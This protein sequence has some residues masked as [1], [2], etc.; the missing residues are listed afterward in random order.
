MWFL[1][2]FARFSSFLNGS[3][4]EA[5]DFLSSNGDNTK[6]SSL[7]RAS[8]WEEVLDGVFKEYFDL[9]GIPL[10]DPSVPNGEYPFDPYPANEVLFWLQIVNSQS[11]HLLGYGRGELVKTIPLGPKESQKVSVKIQTR[12]KM[13]RSSENSSSFETSADSSTTSKDTSEVVSEASEKMNMH[14]EAEISGGYGPFVQAKV[15]GGLAQDT[16]TSSKDTKTR[17]N[18]L[19]KKRQAR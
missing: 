17:L 6:I 14:A 13:T 9:N 12:K 3:K 5:E 10:V 19:M 1:F 16:A 7:V 2:L 4:K 15:S 18:E 8:Y 11:W